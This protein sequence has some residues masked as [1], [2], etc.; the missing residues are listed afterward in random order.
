MRRVSVYAIWALAALLWTA[1][2]YG[3]AAL[4]Y[5]RQYTRS[6]DVP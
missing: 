2:W 6:R 3:V 5:Y 1:L 4:V